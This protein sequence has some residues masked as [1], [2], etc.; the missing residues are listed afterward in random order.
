MSFH[1]PA[2]DSLRDRALHEAGWTV[3]RFWNHEVLTDCAGVCRHLLIIAGI[4]AA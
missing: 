2:R 3:L 1:R 4:N